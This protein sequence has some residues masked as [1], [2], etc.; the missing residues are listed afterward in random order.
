MDLAWVI[1]RQKAKIL[2]ADNDSW[3]FLYILQVIS[4]LF[5]ETLWTIFVSSV[6]FLQEP[7]YKLA[8]YPIRLTWSSMNSCRL[9]T[10]LANILTSE[11]LY[12]QLTLEYAFFWAFF[13]FT[14]II[15]SWLLNLWLYSGKTL[16][17]PSLIV[18]KNH[19]TLGLLTKSELISRWWKCSLR[20]WM[21][22]WKNQ[23]FPRNTETWQIYSCCPMQ[24]LYHHIRMKIT[25]SSWNL[26]KQL[27]LVRSTIYLSINSRGSASISRKTS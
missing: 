22:A 19:W 21:S 17:I 2:L 12:P 7:Q 9:Q 26:G 11:T 4:F 18:Q 6:S 24:I 20:R 23:L 8:V 14:V 10:L 15:S 3:W 27:H 25:Q 13:S 5:E 16:A 1:V